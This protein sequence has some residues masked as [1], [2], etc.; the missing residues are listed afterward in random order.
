MQA[1]TVVDT[2]D[3]TPWSDYLRT[4]MRTFLRT[5]ASSAAILLAAAVVALIWANVDSSSYDD[6]WGKSVTISLGRHAVSQD[7]RGWINDGLMTFFF[8]VV[9]LEARREFDLGELRERQRVALPFIAGL[10]GLAVPAGIYLAINAGHGHTHGWGAAMSS[11]TA[12][13]LG[14][15]A[16]VGPKFPDRLRAFVLTVLVAD[17]L[18]APVI[19]ATV[20]PRDV[21]VDRLV[22]AIALFLILFVVRTMH[23]RGG[24][25][26]FSVG[27]GVWLLTFLSGIDPVVV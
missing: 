1:V 19:I 22:Q 11:D 2:S 4:P 12:F 17:D 26:Y 14:L 15:L 8:F 25:I 27:A 24:L 9:G 3:R 23:V 10:V 13:T 5:E 20:Y 16:L 7:L 21:N 6:L 18:V